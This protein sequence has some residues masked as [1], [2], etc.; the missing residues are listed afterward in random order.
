METILVG[1]AAVLSVGFGCLPFS[2]E[3]SSRRTALDAKLDVQ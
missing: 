2:A 1:L 3:G